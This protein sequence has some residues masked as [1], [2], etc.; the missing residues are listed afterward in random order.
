MEYIKKFLNSL[1]SGI[2]VP[3]LGKGPGF[4]GFG[5]LLALLIYRLLM[6]GKD[7]GTVAAAFGPLVLA[8]Y[9]AGMWKAS[10]DNKAANGG[11]NGAA[12]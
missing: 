6:A 5:A 3:E 9:G 8:V 7:G 4:I 1:L 2:L 12:K 11:A 10:S